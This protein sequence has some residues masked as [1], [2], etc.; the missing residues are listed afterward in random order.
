ME[1]YRF[2]PQRFDKLN[3]SLFHNMFNLK[4]QINWNFNSIYQEMKL[5]LYKIDNFEK[6]SNWE[7]LINKHAGRKFFF[8]LPNISWGANIWASVNVS[9]ATSSTVNAGVLLT[10]RTSGNTLKNIYKNLLLKIHFILK[11]KRAPPPHP[12][13]NLKISLISKLQNFNIKKVVPSQILLQ[14]LLNLYCSIID[15]VFT[16]LPS[17][18]SVPSN[19]QLW[20]EIWQ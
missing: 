7:H 18:K 19:W 10:T 9:G 6:L 2:P 1:K 4:R 11:I 5:N 14:T 15:H 12:Q 8:G 17:L 3:I 20:G 16:C 13:W